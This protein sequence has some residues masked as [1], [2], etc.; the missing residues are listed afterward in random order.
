MVTSFKTYVVKPI[1][2]KSNQGLDNQYFWKKDLST[3]TQVR[4]DKVRTKATD[5]SGNPGNEV[6]W[7]L[8]DIRTNSYDIGLSVMFENEHKG[9]KVEDMLRQYRLDAKVWREELNKIVL[10]DFI[11]KQTWAEIRFGLTPDELTERVPPKPNKDNPDTRTRIMKTGVTLY[12]EVNPFCEDN[13]AGFLKIQILKH[14]R[15]NRVANG[16]DKINTALHGWVMVEQSQEHRA[17]MDLVQKKNLAIG[18]LALLFDKY[19]VT[20]VLEENVA[21]F[22]AASITNPKLIPLVK[23]KPTPNTISEKLDEFLNPRD[24]DMLPWNIKT[25]N[26]V[27]DLFE[28]QPDFFYAKYLVRQAINVQL[29]Q[30]VNSTWHWRRTDGTTSPFESVDAMNIYISTEMDKIESSSLAEFVVALKSKN[31]VIPAHIKV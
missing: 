16:Q 4:L 21:Y 25:F 30:H 31:C 20:T 18:R 22:I 13:L 12:D 28:K 19:P 7:C 26:E 14:D 23:G 5:A 9:K 15:S 2:K 29:V 8:K 3:G 11:S 27:V 17:S 6:I 24:K 10:E 1:P